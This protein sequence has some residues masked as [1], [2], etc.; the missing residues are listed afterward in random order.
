MDAKLP[1]KL[2]IKYLNAIEDSFSGKA[3]FHDEN[4]SIN[5]HGQSNGKII[6]VP[7]SIIGVTDDE[8]LVRV[9]G[10]SGVYVQDHLK[11]NGESKLIEIDSD[12]L[13]SEIASNQNKYD[14]MEI[15]VK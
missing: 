3:V 12:T 8:I 1:L 11:F 13:F 5:I 15:F 10:P 2:K 4:Y 14:T 9:S 6:K 7:F